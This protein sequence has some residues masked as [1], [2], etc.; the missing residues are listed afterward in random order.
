[1]INCLFRKIFI[2]IMLSGFISSALAEP[3]CYITK[4]GENKCIKVSS[5]TNHIPKTISG[6][7][8]CGGNSACGHNN[9]EL[10]WVPSY[11][12]NHPQ[13]FINSDKMIE[14]FQKSQLNQIQMLKS[15]IG[16]SSNQH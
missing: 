12:S 8:G 3:H 13:R 5:P 7:G 11:L 6:G 1:M 9:D 4:E 14:A 2:I 16:I 15:P 10:Q